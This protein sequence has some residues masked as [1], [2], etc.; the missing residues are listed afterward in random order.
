M[1]LVTECVSLTVIPCAEK[2]VTAQQLAGYEM[3]LMVG[4][5]PKATWDDLVQVFIKHQD[6][7]LAI[8]E[9]KL[10]DGTA[11]GFIPRPFAS[12]IMR[13]IQS[14]PYKFYRK[15]IKTL[16]DVGLDAAQAEAAHLATLV[17]LYTCS[18][19]VVQA[20][21]PS[22]V[23][24]ADD[25]A[26]LQDRHTLPRPDALTVTYVQDEL[27]MD[28]ND[29]T[30]TGW[31]FSAKELKSKLKKIFD[32]VKDAAEIEGRV[33]EI[34]NVGL[35]NILQAA[36]RKKYLKP[37][38]T[39]P[40]AKSAPQ[41]L[42]ETVYTDF[43]PFVDIRHLDPDKV[44]FIFHDGKAED[45]PRVATGSKH[46]AH[47]YHADFLKVHTLPAGFCPASFSFDFPWAGTLKGS[48][49]TEWDVKLTPE[50]MRL[51]LSHAKGL[52]L[53]AGGKDINVMIYNSF[54]QGND[55]IKALELEVRARFPVC[56]RGVLW[57][58]RLGVKTHTGMDFDDHRRTPSSYCAGILVGSRVVAQV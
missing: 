21:Y 39:A 14:F 34:V 12:T 22:V 53:A 29:T 10:E 13:T 27:N 7:Q 1:R 35:V 40:V 33:R 6:A 24:K 48:P 23:L 15:V 44:A 4:L 28:P 25:N 36:L 3:F 9:K 18:A 26:L 5:V 11:T 31:S 16:N 45:W 32:K 2:G 52:A 8:F 17:E 43:Q 19:Y 46:E 56:R 37:N 42:V 57:G 58:V 54:E 41:F 47:F 49:N 30:F 38:M 55:L 50:T 51:W 20:I